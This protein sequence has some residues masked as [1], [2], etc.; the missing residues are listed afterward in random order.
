M[1]M[2]GSGGTAS[3]TCNRD[4][5]A[6][7]AAGKNSDELAPANARTDTEA[8]TTQA[9]NDEALVSNIRIGSG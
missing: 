9:E 3:T 6:L 5:F 1:M 4:K 2:P 8:R 7:E